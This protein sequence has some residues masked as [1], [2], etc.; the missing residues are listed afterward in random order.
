MA[1]KPG[2]STT[3]EMTFTMHKGMDGFHDFRVQ[4]ETNDPAAPVKEL[5]VLSNWIP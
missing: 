5:V 1:L 3:L 4:V 2:E